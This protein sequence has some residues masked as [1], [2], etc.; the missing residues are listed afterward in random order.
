MLV[1]LVLYQQKHPPTISLRELGL[2]VADVGFGGVGRAHQPHGTAAFLRR[3]LGI[4]GKVGWLGNYRN[5]QGAVCSSVL[6]PSNFM[7]Y[8][9][10]I[11]YLVRTQIS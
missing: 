11:D 6:M 3:S 4:W 7:L 2:K 5:R 1:W 8:T 9:N 10:I